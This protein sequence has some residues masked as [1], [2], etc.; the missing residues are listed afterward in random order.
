MLPDPRGRRWSARAELTY[1]LLFAATAITIISMVIYLSVRMSTVT[2]DG[3]SPVEGTL[4]VL[5]LSAELFLMFHA[6]GY[7]SSVVKAAK[8][9]AHTAPPLFARASNQPVAVLVAA[10]NEPE[11]VLDQT[12]A[13]V[14]AM[15]YPA[16]HLYLLDDSTKEECR[17]AG[18]RLAARYGATLKQRTNRAG[19]KAGAIND[20]LLELE[21]EFVALLD[22]D[23]RPTEAWLKEVIPMF[24]RG[25]R[26]AMI[27]APQVYVNVAGLPVAE[28]ARFQ[29][30]IFFEYICEGKAFS[31]AIFCCGSN[32]VL[33]R[34]ALLSIEVNVDGRRQFFDETTVTEDFATSVRLHAKG[35]TTDFI[36]EPYVLGMGPE[37][38]PA[39][40]TQHMRWSMGSMAV[41]LKVL[42][43]AI[44]N[45]R[46]L[47]PGQ[48]WEYLLSGS[49]YFVGWANLIF[50]FAPI[51]FLLFGV[52]PVRTQSDLYV[53]FFVPYIF[54]T[55]NLFFFGMKLRR[56]P[57]RG[58]W[59]ASALSFASTWTYAKAAV[60]A[61]FGLKRAFAVTPKGVGGRVP[62]SNMPVEAGLFAINVIAALVGLYHLMFV[63]VE[64]AYVV[65]TIWA[66]YHAILLSTLFFYF[67]RPVQIAA[68]DEMFVDARRAA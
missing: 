33:R 55:M 3:V 34:S 60:V 52:R 36:N 50:M 43:M 26:I 17:L 58:V 12:L 37:T 65:T 10:F 18:Q 49:Y 11:D 38:L 16:I 54:F 28:A 32:V 24:D 63:R 42:R 21:E 62:I 59:L 64:V 39:Y 51:A 44:T 67:N 41:G 9:I 30:A 46:M 1:Q 48:Y 4:A 13:A 27:Q 56:Y 15:D 29:Q 7:F 66:T 8:R 53:I 35:W 22:A 19:Y 2:L 61:V 57:V 68:Q 5:L 14:R 23:Q 40:F 45:P 47:T 31:N 6:V 20:L 25:P